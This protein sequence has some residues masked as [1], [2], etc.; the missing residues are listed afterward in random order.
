MI[1]R[2]AE[3][4][5]YDADSVMPRRWIRRRVTGQLGQPLLRLS[6][7]PNAAAALPGTRDSDSDRARQPV[8]LP[9]PGQVTVTVPAAAAA[10]GRHDHRGGSCPMAISKHTFNYS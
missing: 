5:Y 9:G 3:F 7:A 4:K 2:L 10:A 1:I 8:G 6:L